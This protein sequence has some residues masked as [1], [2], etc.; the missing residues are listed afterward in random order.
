MTTTV[1]KGSRSTRSNKRGTRETEAERAD[2]F[3]LVTEPEAEIEAEAEAEGVCAG[4]C[5]GEPEF[6]MESGAGMRPAGNMAENLC[7]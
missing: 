6:E 3:T 7:G 1:A 5:A 2:A 4:D